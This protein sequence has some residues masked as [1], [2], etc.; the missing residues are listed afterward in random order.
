MC[1]PKILPN[2]CKMVVVASRSS[3]SG[4]MK[5]AASSAYMEV[6]HLATGR[7]KA[8]RTPCCVA[9]S[10]RRCSGSMARMNSMGDRGSPYRTP[11]LWLKVGPCCPFSSALDEVVQNKMDTT[12]AIAVRNLVSVEPQEDSSS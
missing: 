2:S 4:L 5:I 6:L 9:M 7:G 12:R 11:L 1:K 8:V 10:S 3:L